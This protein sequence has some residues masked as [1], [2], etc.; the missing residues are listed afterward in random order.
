MMTLLPCLFVFVIVFVIVFVC[1][2]GDLPGGGR[3]TWEG[4]RQVHVQFPVQP[5]PRW[6]VRSEGGESE[7]VRGE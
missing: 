4:V 7:E 5:Q 1:D 6:V 2:L 3:Q